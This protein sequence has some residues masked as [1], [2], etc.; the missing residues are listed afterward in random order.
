M[1]AAR[2]SIERSRLA[3]KLD[4]LLHDARAAWCAR[5]GPPL[6]IVSDAPAVRERIV[7]RP[8]SRTVW[9][10]PLEEAFYGPGEGRAIVDHPEATL[11]RLADIFVTGSEGLLFA[12]PRALLRF[13]A[14]QNDIAQK[15][16]RRPIKALARRI[17][18]AVL[19]LGGRGVGNRGHFL[20]EHLPRLL[21]AR[22]RLGRDFPLKILV[23]PGHRDWQAQYLARLGEEPND[24][25]EGSRGTVYCPQAWFVPNLSAT[26]RA[27]LYQPDVYREIARRFKSGIAPRGAKRRLF[28]TRQDAPSRR[29]K[30]EDDVFALLRAAWPDL[31][32]VS[33][34]GMS[35]AVQIALFCEAQVVIGPHSQ[36]FRNLL[37]CEGAL[38]IQL[39]PGRRGRDNEYRIWADNYDRLGSIHANRCLSLYSEEPYSDGDWS[40]P[41]ESLRSALRRLADLGEAPRT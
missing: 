21:L 8:A 24:V 12:G 22:E 33:L 37:Y 9:E 27:D 36:S 29:L 6:E 39:V 31:E 41:L 38:S 7:L 30:N 28:L 32:R 40:F 4:R 26:E 35:L 5:F 2:P 19:P 34:A 15:K 10:N 17:D 3:N 1:A 16:I 18:G 11:Y 13:C 14:S 25:I 23:T 20:S